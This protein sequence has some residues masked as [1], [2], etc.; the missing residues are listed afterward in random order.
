M[1]LPRERIHAATCPES[2]ATSKSWQRRE[3]G[4][5]SLWRLQK[6]VAYSTDVLGNQT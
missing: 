2:G 4:C 1:T 6:F 3:S 5:Q